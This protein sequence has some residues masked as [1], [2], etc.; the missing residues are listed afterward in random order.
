MIKILVLGI[1]LIVTS[2]YAATTLI[3]DTVA[4]AVTN[5]KQR[6]A[7]VAEN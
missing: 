4:A 6:I 3:S 1:L 7:A 2:T 5:E